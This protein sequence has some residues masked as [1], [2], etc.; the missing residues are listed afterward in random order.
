MSLRISEE[1]GVNPS[2]GVCMYCGGDGDVIL[3]GALTV[4]KYKDTFGQD[5]SPGD[6]KNNMAK[7]PHRMSMGSDPCQK[8]ADRM[9]DGWVYFMETSESRVPTGRS[10]GIR[11]DSA[12]GLLQDIVVDGSAEEQVAA[13]KKH[14]VMHMPRE[15]F[16]KIF[17]E[18]LDE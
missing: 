12:A 10:V 11:E 16:E 15:V 4:G 17:A 6:V 18:A 8:C 2:I 7:A 1:W 5:P 9:K 14:R 3:M 13:I